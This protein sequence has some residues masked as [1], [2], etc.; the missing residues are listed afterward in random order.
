M[1]VQDV[2]TRVQRTFGDEAAV[3][4]KNDDVIRWINDAMV[5]IVKHNDTALQKTDTIDL[6]A[7]TSQYTL[8]ADAL[9]VRSLRYKFSSMESYTR[10]RYK[11]MQQMDEEMDGWDGTA[12]NSGHPLY[13]TM[14]EGNILLFPT[15]EES[16]TDGLKILYNQKP[17][18]VTTIADN[19]SLPLIYHNTVVKYC[20]WQASLLDE[21][22]EPGMMYRAEFQNDMDVLANNETKDPIATYSTI[23]VLADDL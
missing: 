17:T 19:L 9:I 10:L 22:H 18:D 15:P 12:Y 5:E 2:I 16:N 20:L 14:Y 11:S 7:D 6:V 3:Q 13:F 23:T 8:P 1:N 21:D 4:V